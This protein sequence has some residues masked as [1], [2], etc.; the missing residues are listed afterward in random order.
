MNTLQ[1]SQVDFIEDPLSMQRQWVETK[2][3]VS[4]CI[5]ITPLD[6]CVVLRCP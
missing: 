6:V 5:R 3:A 4:N 1:Q 2:A